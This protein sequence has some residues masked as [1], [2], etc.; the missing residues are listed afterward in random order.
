MKSMRELFT[1]SVGIFCLC[2]CEKPDFLEPAFDPSP[3]S[4]IKA[5]VVEFS[6]EFP[7]SLSG[8]MAWGGQV[9]VVGYQDGAQVIP[10]SDPGN[11]AIA[12]SPVI[13]GRFR[14]ASTWKLALPGQSA[15]SAFDVS[16]RVLGATG[17][18]VREASASYI[19]V[20]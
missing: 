8:F 14:V 2:G 3:G 7:Y 13:E 4:N 11:L 6:S 9:T 17:E 18:F 1:L 19:I 20:K 16:F 5:G 12:L 10:V 15:T